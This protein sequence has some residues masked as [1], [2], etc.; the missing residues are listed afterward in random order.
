MRNITGSD[1]LLPWLQFSSSLWS[2]QSNTS[3]Q[4][5]RRGIQWARF[6]HRNSS[7]LHSF[8]QPIYQHRGA[9]NQRKHSFEEDVKHIQRKPKCWMIHEIT[10]TKQV[11]AH[12]PLMWWEASLLKRNVLFCLHLETQKN[13]IGR[14]AEQGVLQPLTDLIWA[15]QAVVMS[16]TPQAGR[17]TPSAGT[18]ILV[19]WTRRDHWGRTRQISFAKTKRTS[20]TYIQY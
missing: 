1:P 12:S 20:T 14:N 8:T 11:A 18:D 6:R 19:Q 5:Q 9:V 17:N 13:K 3:S 16:V 7:S 4:R 15:I 2:T 10:P